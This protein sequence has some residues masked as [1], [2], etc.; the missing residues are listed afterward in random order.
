[1]GSKRKDFL[2][3]APTTLLKSKV[4]EKAK[5]NA[6]TF[7]LP[8]PQ[9]GKQTSFV[10]T[11]ADVCIY[12][13]AGGGGKSWALLRKSLINIDNPNY[14]AVIFRRTSPEIIWLSPWCNSKRG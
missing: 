2:S 6:V 9:P 13:G 12:G 10:N 3:G 4:N 14:G 1:M 5:N 8:D 11:R 7:T